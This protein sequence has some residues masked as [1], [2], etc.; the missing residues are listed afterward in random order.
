MAV[1]FNICQNNIESCFDQGNKKRVTEFLEKVGKKLES[2]RLF[3][4]QSTFSSLDGAIKANSYP[5]E[6]LSIVMSYDV[7]SEHFASRFFKPV[8][9]IPKVLNSEIAESKNVSVLAL[10]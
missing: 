3:H 8:R 9:I 6:L 2:I 7:P 5:P 1:N 10:S 4:Q